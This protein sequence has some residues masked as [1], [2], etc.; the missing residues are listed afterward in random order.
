M[1][2][3]AP[4]LPYVSPD[5]ARVRV[6]LDAVCRTCKTR[7]RLGRT[8]QG[9]LME[10][11]QWY[12]RHRDHD[13]EYLSPRRRLPPR[14]RDTV[15]WLLGWAPWWLGVRENAN[16]LIEWG[17][18]TAVTI[19]PASVASSTTFVVGRA[20]TAVDNTTN[21]YVDFRPTVSRIT[22]G[23]TP[24]VDREIRVYSY[25]D[26]TDTPTYPDTITGSDATVTL[27]NAYMLEA[28]LV[29]T[30]RTGVS[31]ASNVGY[32]IR[33]M[34]IAQAWGHAPKRWGLFVTHN[35]NVALHSTAG[36][37]VLSYI[38]AFYKVL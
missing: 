21:D 38:G 27:T 22:T 37:H 11:W 36:N 18:S 13:I 16:I 28:A 33:C 4:R 7:H 5:T 31:V 34:S 26:L 1:P 8:P 20:S 2:T 12:E 25:T 23:T 29:L 3:P 24:I 30:G 6:D 9:F 35:T 32:P 15:Y 19:S 17:V 14:F 10:L